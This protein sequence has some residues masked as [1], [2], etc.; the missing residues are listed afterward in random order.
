MA[1]LA[2]WDI[3]DCGFGRDGEELL[4]NIIRIV[5]RL[6]LWGDPWGCSIIPMGLCY[7]KAGG[8]TINSII[9]V[10]QLYKI[11]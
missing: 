2:E 6:R 9:E 7:L 8:K 5:G 4:F 1:R 3:R 10:Y 11:E